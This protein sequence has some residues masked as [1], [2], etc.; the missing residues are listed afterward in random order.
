MQ[1]S[2]IYKHRAPKHNTVF[3]YTKCVLLCVT[4]V[5]QTLLLYKTI[6]VVHIL[7]EIEQTDA[8]RVVTVPP[9]HH[10]RCDIARVKTSADRAHHMR[11]HKHR[12]PPLCNVL[13]CTTLASHAY[14]N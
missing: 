5:N 3:K 12:A 4:F 7:D 10:Q 11:A 2:L 9:P 1:C 6:Q 13:M 14:A 8:M